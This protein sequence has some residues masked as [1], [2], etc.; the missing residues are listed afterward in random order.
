M[1]KTKSFHCGRTASYP[2]AP[3]QIPA[4]GTIAPGILEV[5]A[6][7]KGIKPDRGLLSSKHVWGDLRCAVLQRQTVPSVV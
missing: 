4:C 7:A 5:L 3:A 1:R 6:S 2:T